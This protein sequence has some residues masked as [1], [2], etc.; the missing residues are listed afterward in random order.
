MPNIIIVIIILGTAHILPKVLT[1]KNKRAN[2][3]SR[4]RGTINNKDNSC[5]NV[6]PWDMVCL[7]NMCMDTL[8][9]GDDDDDDDDNNNNN[10]NNIKYKLKAFPAAHRHNTKN[11]NTIMDETEKIPDWLT[12][13][14]TYLL[15]KSGDSKRVRNY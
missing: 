4:N 1:Q 6:S 3:G 13:G 2:A 8:H 10:N 12:I 5:N 11:F 15:P 14:I 7:G 9:K